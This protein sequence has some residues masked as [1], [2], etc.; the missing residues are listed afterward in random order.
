[1]LGRL[2]VGLGAVELSHPDRRTCPG[3]RGDMGLTGLDMT[4]CVQADVPAPAVVGPPTR[5]AGV[6]AVNRRCD[7]VLSMPPGEGAG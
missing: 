3:E 7:A 5:D 6:I 4:N 1:M 2:D